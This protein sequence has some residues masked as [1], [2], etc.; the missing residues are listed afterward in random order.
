MELFWENAGW[1]RDDRHLSA[2]ERAPFRRPFPALSPVPGLQSIRGPRQIG[3]S[4]WLKTV[5]FNEVKAGKKCFF[6]SCEEIQD[7]KELS[8]LLKPLR[9]RHVI[10]LDE[11]SF[12]SEWDRA[13]KYMIDS[14]YQGSIVVTGSNSFDLRRGLDRMPGRWAQ[15]LNGEHLLLPMEFDEWLA[16]RAQAGW[17]NASDPVYNLAQFFKIGGFPIALCEA[18]EDFKDPVESRRTYHR[19]IVGD[20]AR[21]NRQEVYLREILGQLAITMTSAISLQKLAQK[22]QMMSYHTAQEYI[23][24]LEDCF[25]L[26]TLYCMD[27][28]SGSIRFKKEKKFYFTDPILYWVA[29]EWAGY[30]APSHWEEQLAEMVAHEFLSRRSKR[31]GYL[32]VPKGEVDF[33]EP[34]KWAIEVK[35]AP[36]PRNL[37]R[38]YLDLAIPSKLVWSQSNFLKGTPTS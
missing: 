31:L 7:Y 10:L 30:S 25:A 5:L 26:K 8:E 36:V 37:S 6:Q 2:L 34:G 14:G 21:R 11:I 18:G 28:S 13:I 32:S 9:P 35:W 22:T 24:V 12:V 4:S 38:A 27:P 1:E 29:L 19:W 23:S 33:F 15:T 3:K 20:A 16:M 17:Q